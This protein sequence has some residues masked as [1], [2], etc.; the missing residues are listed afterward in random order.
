MSGVN[1][2]KP[3][4]I[5]ANDPSA[6][7]ALQRITVNWVRLRRPDTPQSAPSGTQD[8]E[9]DTAAG[10]NAEEESENEEEHTEPEGREDEKERC[11][12]SGKQSTWASAFPRLTVTKMRMKRSI[13][14][15]RFSCGVVAII[16]RVP[17]PPEVL[18]R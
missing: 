6:V 9:D 11:G 4:R 13:M 17:L 2:P 12:D 16:A 1:F 8:A 7:I 10:Q 5:H 18:L 3:C 15:V 14:K